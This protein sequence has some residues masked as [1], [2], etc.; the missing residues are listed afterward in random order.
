VSLA[1]FEG[2]YVHLRFTARDASGQH[3]AQVVTAWV[4]VESSPALV[5]VD[6]VPGFI[7][8]ADATRILYMDWPDGVGMGHL[9]LLDR[10]T[11]AV[12]SIGTQFAGVFFE[13]AVAAD[14]TGYSTIAVQLTSV[15]AAYQRGSFRY[16]GGVWDFKS[17]SSTFLEYDQFANV[18][19]RGDYAV[20]DGYGPNMP[21]PG[22]T[23]RLLRDFQRQTTAMV[24]AAATIAPNG[25]LLYFSGGNVWRVRSGVTS[26]LTTTGSVSTTSP[27]SSDGQH[28]LYIDSI[29]GMPW[30]MMVDD[31]GTTQIAEGATSY[32]ISGGW[33]A[34]TKPGQ[35]N[36]PA[37]VW[38]RTPDGT[39]TQVTFL[40]SP[41]GI[42]GLA[43]DGAIIAVSNN[44]RYLAVPGGPLLAPEVG[45]DFTVTFNSPRVTFHSPMGLRDAFI[46]GA[47]HTAVGGTLFR[48]APCDPDAGPCPD[49][50]TPPAPDGGMPPA[51]DGGATPTDAGAPSADSHAGDASGPFDA[52]GPTDAAV[53]DSS[54]ATDAPLEQDCGC[55]LGRANAGGHLAELG[56]L[57]LALGSLRRRTSARRARPRR[58]APG[59]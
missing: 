38:R 36:G 25:D 24:T 47:W 29:A 33:V 1:L 51:P 52:Q 32:Q 10:S 19:K 6:K 49:G 37:Q 48:I 34:Y 2:Q 18:T 41:S 59:N 44:R 12:T 31:G 23:N 46:G 3:A 7:Y 16:G 39:A 53:A 40:G 45:T 54:G 27:I 26:Q 35:A 17:P 56:A 9:S 22:G 14:Q 55:R 8:D 43:P 50:G 4:A 30:L 5:K 15:G 28:V 42:Q 20:W 13:P 11:R 57:L 21:G 58:S